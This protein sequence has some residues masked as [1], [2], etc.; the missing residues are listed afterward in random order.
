M[1]TMTACI[2]I[3][4]A[5]VGSILRKI[6]DSALEELAAISTRAVELYLGID[7][8]QGISKCLL[9]FDEFAYLY[10]LHGTMR[11]TLV[12]IVLALVNSGV[13]RSVHG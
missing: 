6:S 5:R 9:R 10:L 3:T 2:L 12:H 8:I 1:K 7:G 13:E 11:D 4:L